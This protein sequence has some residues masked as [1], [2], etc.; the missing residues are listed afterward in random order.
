MV[1]YELL[2]GVPAW[3]RETMGDIPYDELLKKIRESDPK[4]P[5]AR[6]PRL[7][8][9][10]DWIVLKAIDKD[11]RRRYGSASALADDIS[12]YLNHE[13]IRA[14]PPSTVYR[15]AKFVRN[16]VFGVLFSSLLVATLAVGIVVA[17][18]FALRADRERSAAENLRAES[19]REFSRADLRIAN[20]IA[21]SGRHSAAIAHL[22]RA[23]RNDPENRPAMQKLIN[24]LAYRGF[25]IPAT[26]PVMM[27]GSW[28]QSVLIGE[29]RLVTL[30]V[31]L[32]TRPVESGR[33]HRSD[34]DRSS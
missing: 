13:P 3:S 2:A 33:A 14:R 1:L 34:G 32:Q 23:L 20:E 18:V 26:A 28:R 10:L 4:P 24:D 11:R 27:E 15:V 21:A 12:R 31:D 19:K 29:D 17:T 25:P 5:S 7:P 16:T 22:C 8:R 9:D 30:G 6:Q